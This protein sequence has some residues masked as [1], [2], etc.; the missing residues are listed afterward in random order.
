[1]THEHIMSPTWQARFLTV[2]F[3]QS[4]SDGRE[5]NPKHTEAS[6]RHFKTTISLSSHPLISLAI[7]KEDG[8]RVSSAISYLPS[9][10]AAGSDLCHSVSCGFSNSKVVYLFVTQDFVC[11]YLMGIKFFFFFTYICT[12]FDLNFLM[13]SFGFRSDLLLVFLDLGSGFCFD[14]RYM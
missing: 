8:E 9:S 1:M 12:C 5:R 7:H 6:V 11:Y 13:N 2:R 3:A 10:S 4:Q 14:G